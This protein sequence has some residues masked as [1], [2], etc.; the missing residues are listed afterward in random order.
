SELGAEGRCVLVPPIGPVAL[1]PPAEMPEACFP[2]SDAAYVLV[3][4]ARP[5]PDVRPA[6]CARP[7]YWS[8]VVRSGGITIDTQGTRRD[9]AAPCMARPW[10]P[11]KP[12]TVQS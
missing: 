1:R 3:L 10:K 4:Q 9:R 6:S 12:E 8:D 5:E 7:V 11:C 2:A